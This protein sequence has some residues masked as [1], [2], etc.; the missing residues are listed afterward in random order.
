M[1]AL[2][3]AVKQEGKRSG[4]PEVRDQALRARQVT[5]RRGGRSGIS[6]HVTSD[7]ASR[8]R[9]IS[10]LWLAVHNDPKKTVAD[11]AA[12]FYFAVGEVL[13]GRPL[14]ALSLSNIDRERL[15]AHAEE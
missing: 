8:L 14:S 12:E 4:V 5:R 9:D 10:A 3:Y 11:L 7:V 15:K 13:E 6:N 2:R 1:P